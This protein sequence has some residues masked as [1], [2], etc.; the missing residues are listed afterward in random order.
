VNTRASGA[1]TSSSTKLATT[2]PRR[3][4]LLRPS[5]SAPASRFSGPAEGFHFPGVVGGLLGG[6]VDIEYDDG[7]KVTHDLAKEVGRLEE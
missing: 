6:K 1:A 4:P 3:L 7:D 2:A 5:P